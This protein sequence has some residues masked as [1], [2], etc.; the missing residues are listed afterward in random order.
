MPQYQVTVSISNTRLP[1]L[2]VLQKQFGGSIHKFPSRPKC[3]PAW[4]WHLGEGGAANFL[5]QIRPYLR[6][7]ADQAWLALEF[8]AQKT[9][10]RRGVRLSDEEVALREGFYWAVKLA[11]GRVD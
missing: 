10:G 11:K 2:E 3:Q 4:Q 5:E 6:D 1:N 7:K 8:L 9:P